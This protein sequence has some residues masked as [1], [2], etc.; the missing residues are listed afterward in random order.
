MLQHRRTAK[1]FR[2]QDPLDQLALELRLFQEH[3]FRDSNYLYVWHSFLPVQI[4]CI[5]QTQNSCNVFGQVT[6]VFIPLNLSLYPLAPGT[7]IP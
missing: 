5:E 6:S 7:C 4:N 2:M 3:V 1:T